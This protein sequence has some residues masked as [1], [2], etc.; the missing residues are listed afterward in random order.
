MPNSRFY[1][2]QVAAIDHRRTWLIRGSVA[3]GAALIAALL[4]WDSGFSPSA[5]SDWLQW[6]RHRAHPAERPLLVPKPRV[7]TPSRREPITSRLG[8]DAS[9]SK[10]RMPLILVRTIPGQNVHSGQALLGADRA[11]PQT[12]MAGAIL[13]SGARIDEIYRDHIVLVKGNE[14]AELYVDG[15]GSV[16]SARALR[17]L[18]SVGAPPPPPEK[19]HF[20]VDPITDYLRPVPVYENGA[21]SG[22]QVFPGE[23]ASAFNQWGLKPGDVVTA[24]DGAALTDADQAM[25]LFHALADGQAVTAT[26]RRAGGEPIQVAL[27]GAD[28]VKLQ[29]ARAALASARGP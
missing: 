15:M 3:L 18:Y 13:E 2:D 5:L 21:V 9:A 16:S 19:P 10:V 4:V 7:V 14:R 26:V 8:T 29:D 27:D 24:L 22:F 12:Y 20:S 11:H 25:E 6:A 23:Q 28:I 17:A 1:R